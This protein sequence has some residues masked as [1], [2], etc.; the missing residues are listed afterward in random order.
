MTS[1]N[2]YAGHNFPTAEQDAGALYPSPTPC[3]Q[4]V[5]YPDL[6][7]QFTA[8]TSFLDFHH[9]SF[10]NNYTTT[11]PSDNNIAGSNELDCFR[12]RHA[13]RTGPYFGQAFPP[14]YNALQG[15]FIASNAA[16]DGPSMTTIYPL[17]DFSSWPSQH[18]SIPPVL[19]KDVHIDPD[20]AS[21]AAFSSFGGQVTSLSSHEA[22]ISHKL[23]PGDGNS[24][25]HAFTGNISN[26]HA[27]AT[28]VAASSHSQHVPVT[29]GSKSPDLRAGPTL[30]SRS[31]GLVQTPRPRSGGAVKLP[32]LSAGSRRAT[33]VDKLADLFP[34][35]LQAAGCESRFSG[36]NEWKRHVNTL[37]VCE[38]LWV[39]TEASCEL[40]TIVTHQRQT[41]NGVLIP[42]RG[43]IFCRKDLYMA[44]LDRKH[45]HLLPGKLA[46]SRKFPWPGLERIAKKA[47]HRRVRLPT[48]M[49]CCVKGC[50]ATF[51]GRSA[52]D[53]FLEH[54]A[55]H[56]KKSHESPTGVV[57]V[58]PWNNTSLMRWGVTAGFMHEAEGGGAWELRNPVINI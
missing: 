34:C 45:S 31:K 28:T 15:P 25:I 10:Y 47:W 30:P 14:S 32:K 58:D 13:L 41:P 27:P 6:E 52:W 53:D 35:L 36:K 22:N 38:E 55:D 37:H 7:P 46:T 4:D 39:C 19:Q 20:L 42:R 51:S 18:P 48:E 24:P 2:Y 1:N 44:H 29:P 26:P 8:S 12:N 23:G 40:H 33:K 3:H 43:R 50:P 11:I 16:C 17:P 54:T 5:P 57:D 9:Q 49:A 21:W 56:F